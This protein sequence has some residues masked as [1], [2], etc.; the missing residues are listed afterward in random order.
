VTERN[1]LVHDPSNAGNTAQYREVRMRIRSAL[2]AAT[3]GITALAT[4]ASGQTTL[5]IGLQEDPDTLDAAKNWSFVGRQIFASMCDKIVDTAPD[6]SFVPQIATEWS[7]AADGKSMTFKIRPGMKFHDGETVDAA[8]VKYSLDRALTLPDSR[9]K[10]EISAVSHIEV[11]D[12]LTLRVDLTAPF[13]PLLAQFADRA[14]VIVAPKAAEA[15]GDQFGAKP[16]CAGPYKFV[17]RVVQDRIVLEKFADYWDK[18][19]YHF[20]RVIFLAIPDTGVRFANLRSGQLD[21]MERLLPSDLDALK[22]D[23]RLAT[24]AITGLGYQGI[25]FNLANGEMAN[26]PFG[27]DKRVRAAL[28]AALDRNIL[29]EVV[30]GGQYAAGNQ[31]QTPENFYYAK[32]LPVE[33]RNLALAKTLLREAGVTNPSFTLLVPNSNDNQQAAEIMQSMAKEA[34]IEIKLQTVEFITMLQQAKDGKFDADFVG[35]S[36]RIDPDANISTLLACKA[37]GN[38]GHYCNAEF[39]TLLDR[40]RTTSDKDAR[41]AIYDKVAQILIDEKPILYLWHQK[42]I[43][44]F[45]SKLNGFVPYPDGLIRLRDVSYRP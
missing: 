39:N 44:G 40:A 27:K 8:A 12:P 21:L 4:G 7:T 30:Y 31:P 11:T 17:E 26:N 20:D 38:D 22:K 13:S 35:W 16:V 28:D 41:K 19:H 9:R 42:W 37:P 2:F 18:D 24:A 10:S 34:G 6:Q 45:T 33:K 14:G 43:Y 29:N 23:P 36:G 5:R 25:T 1:D 32:S 3:F 15:E